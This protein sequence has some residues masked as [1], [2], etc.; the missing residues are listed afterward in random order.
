MMRQTY[1]P[2]ATNLSSIC[3]THPSPKVGQ[4]QTHVESARLVIWVLAKSARNYG[5]SHHTMHS[6][7]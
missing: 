3:K 4:N 1:L 7:R 2:K 5:K 6:T